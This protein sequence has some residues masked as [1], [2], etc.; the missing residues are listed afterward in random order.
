MD[1]GQT[2]FAHGTTLEVRTLLMR[3]ALSMLSTPKVICAALVRREKH[4]KWCELGI[5]QVATTITPLGT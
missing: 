2:L 4:D 1:L 5:P 3:L